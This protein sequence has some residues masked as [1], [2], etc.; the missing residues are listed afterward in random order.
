MKFGKYYLGCSKALID[1]AL[2]LLHS[3]RMT[4]ALKRI[5]L[6]MKQFA[7]QLRLQI[8]LNVFGKMLPCSF[9]LCL[10]RSQT[11]F[12]SMIIDRLQFC[13]SDSICL[14]PSFYFRWKF[15][16][17]KMT[18]VTSASCVVHRSISLSFLL[19]KQDIWLH[20]MLFISSLYIIIFKVK[21]V[22]WKEA[23]NISLYS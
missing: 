14:M 3:G 13:Y 1:Q 23:G 21:A 7:S 10:C 17:R 11:H 20:R 16:V 22:V 2:Y 6:S 4:S 5:H 9:C 19:K 8:C 15:C 12:L 18:V